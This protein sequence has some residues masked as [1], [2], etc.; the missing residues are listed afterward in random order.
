MKVSFLTL[1]VSTLSFTTSLSAA[2][3][4]VTADQASYGLGDT[5]TLTVVGSIIP[6]VEVTEAF[7]VVLDSPANVGFVGSS[8][9]APIPPDCMFGP[10]VW[11]MD[12]TQG[13]L[14]GNSLTA[15][16]QFC[17]GCVLTF[18]N[19]ATPGFSSA[20]I[21]ATAILTATSA[22]LNVPI[23]FGQFTTFFGVGPGP[24]TTVNIVPEPSTAVLIGLGVLGLTRL[25][26]R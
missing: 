8:A 6:G 2:T 16:N 3:L 25:R 19:N 23:D 26:G 11:T 15:F 13:T 14:S 1:V 22:G 12:S 17:D 21:T 4:A 18:V 5:I 20:Y 7:V 9:D 24:G 10:C